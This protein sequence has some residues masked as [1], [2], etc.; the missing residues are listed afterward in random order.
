MWLWLAFSLRINPCLTRFPGSCILSAY[1]DQFSTPLKGEQQMT[2]PTVTTPGRDKIEQLKI[3]RPD[4]VIEVTRI[5]DHD[6]RWDGDDPIGDEFD[7][8][9][10]EVTAY[11]IR[12]G[13]RIE[14]TATLGGSWYDLD[15]HDAHNQACIAEI[16]GY[17]PQMIDEAID[18]LD[19]QLKG[20]R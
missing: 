19:A 16:S 2:Q 8:F 1:F 6:T 9:D 4:I 12:N 5:A 7:C 20:G 18:E 10:H 11:T 13:V 14:G 15:D 3:S 17:L